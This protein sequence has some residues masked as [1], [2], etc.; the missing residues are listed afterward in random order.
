MI[1]LNLLPDIKLEYLRAQ[2]TKRLFMTLAFMIMVGSVAAVLI[3]GFV[4]YIVQGRHLSNQEADIEK[5]IS[6]LQSEEDLA[7]ILTVQNQLEDLPGLHDSKPVVSRLFNYLTILVP[8]DVDLDSIEIQFSEEEGGEAVAEL[9]GRS[10]N[11]KSVN[12][13]SDSLKNAEYT[14][15]VSTQASRA[16]NSVTLGS[17]GKS[18]SETTFTINALIDPLI[19][20]KAQENIKLIH[21]NG[22][23]LRSP[24]L[25]HFEVRGAAFPGNFGAGNL[26]LMDSKG[27]GRSE[28]LTI[29]MLR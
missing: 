6:T 8:S 29:V 12:V 7:S 15:S 23:F 16:F 22:R 14:S 20:D 13:L 3:F 2:R 19:F 11:F 17:I 28:H 5:K 25:L 4:V 21:F 1:S 24:T 9:V 10:K 18:T 27:G 26:G